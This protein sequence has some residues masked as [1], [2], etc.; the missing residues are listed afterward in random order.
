MNGGSLLFRVVLV[1]LPPNDFNR[2]SSTWNMTSLDR[3]KTWRGWVNHPKKRGKRPAVVEEEGRQEEKLD[4]FVLSIAHGKQS[5]PKR[6]AQHFPIELRR[7]SSLTLFTTQNQKD[8]KK[9]ALR[10]TNRKSFPSEQKVWWE[11]CRQ[12]K[13]A[14]Q[15]CCSSN[16]PHQC[17]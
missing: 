8:G 10:S 3:R 4:S 11:R 9:F 17:S 1:F 16:A 14:A 5:P 12:R 15:R 2:L 6:T 7:L 13:N